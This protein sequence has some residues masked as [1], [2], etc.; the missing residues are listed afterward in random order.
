MVS[1]MWLLA[2]VAAARSGVAGAS[3]DSGAAKSNVTVLSGMSLA[4]LEASWAEVVAE[5]IVPQSLAPEVPR[6]VGGDVDTNPA[7]R[8]T[9]S[10]QSKWN[11]AWQHF[12]GGS[13]VHP[14]WVLT[15][16]HCLRFGAPGRV[17]LGTYNLKAKSPLV[18]TVTAVQVHPLFANVKNDI[19]LLRLSAPAQGLPLARLSSAVNGAIEREGVLS[20]VTGWGY[21]AEGSGAVQSLLRSVTIPLVSLQACSAAYYALDWNRICAGLAAGGKDSCQG[22]SGGP[23]LHIDNKTGVMTQV[24]IV[25]YGTGC[26]RMGYYGVYTRNSYFLPWV[27]N[28]LAQSGEMLPQDDPA[29][30]P[31]PAPTTPAPAPT[32]APTADRASAFVS[33]ERAFCSARDPAVCSG[34]KFSKRARAPVPKELR[35][36]R[37]C[38]D[39]SGVCDSVFCGTGRTKLG[40]AFAAA[41]DQHCTGT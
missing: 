28:T 24:G 12:C 39:N 32:P 6:I 26:A 10:L 25:S 18:R 22:D 35:G 20:T 8:F 17:V 9:V 15:A 37:R 34:S 14:S 21:T 2:A 38:F 16:A 30:K 41:L 23:L 11:G 4:Q 19:A 5:E 33:A 1:A 29:L 13:L 36:Q 7:L 31:T 40:S 27:R 3:A